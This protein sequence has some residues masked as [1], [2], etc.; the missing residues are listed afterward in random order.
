[1]QYRKL[2]KTGIDVSFLSLGTLTMGPLQRNMRCEEG[3]ALIRSACAMGINLFDT[4]EMYR[5]Y[6][7]IR[8]AKL[9]ASSA[10]VSKSYAFDGAGMEESVHRALRETGRSA[11]EVFMLHQQ[12]SALTLEGHGEALDCLRRARKEGLV[13]HIG[14]STH[15]VAAVEAACRIPDIEVVFAILNYRG[16]GIMD[17]SRG[18]M[19]KA[20]RAAARLGKGVMVMKPIG[21]GHLFRELKRSFQYLA[22]CDFIST[23]VVGAQSADELTADAAFLEGAEVPEEVLSRLRLKERK[24]NIEYESCQKCGRCAAKCPQKALM[25][26]EDRL[27]IDHSRCIL[28]AYCASV[29]PDFCLEVI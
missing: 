4:A 13:G 14:I 24:L 3:A 15:H 10:V 18:D 5:T 17:G 21:G 29:C 27:C 8:A 22:G 28:C 16:L 26:T 20:L 12:E 9:G 25:L 1:M 6:S 11:V 2:G 23:V 7:H 19:E